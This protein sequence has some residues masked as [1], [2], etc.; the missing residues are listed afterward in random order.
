MPRTLPWQQ[1]AP[2]VRPPED[3]GPE[4]VEDDETTEAV[5]TSSDEGEYIGKDMCASASEG[6]SE[7]QPEMIAGMMHD[8]RY[9][10]TEI[11]LESMADFFSKEHYKQLYRYLN[12]SQPSQES[13]ATQTS[14]LAQLLASPSK[15]RKYTRFNV[16]PRAPQL[17]RGDTRL[18]VESK[19]DFALHQ[20]N[21][22][23]SEYDSEHMQRSIRGVPVQK[24]GV[25]ARREK[26]SIPPVALNS[27]MSGTRAH[28]AIPGERDLPVK[29]TSGKE[30][31]D[32]GEIDPMFDFVRPL[33][34]TKVRA[35]HAKKS[36]PGSLL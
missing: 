31:I 22:T 36:T 28:S 3:N 32:S 15:N 9:V 10:M 35:K 30:C 29:T 1:Q 12:T 17:A 21:L 8:D 2:K 27:I 6:S 16:Q 4:K 26:V 5:Q 34:T 19:S 20:Q 23:S 25:L 18:S 24:P 13:A 11:E 33:N 7:H 14:S